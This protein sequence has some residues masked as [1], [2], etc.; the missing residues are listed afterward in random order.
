[1]VLINEYIKK[2]LV[3]FLTIAFLVISNGAVFAMDTPTMKIYGVAIKGYDPVAYFT[4][5]RAIQGNS[6]YSYD[7]NEASWYFSTP[8][9]RDLFAANPGKYAPNRGG[10]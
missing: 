3:V 5:N 2:S 8:E 4:E 6:A 9:H 10:F 1:M 7:W